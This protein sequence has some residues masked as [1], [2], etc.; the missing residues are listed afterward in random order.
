MQ[1]SLALSL[2]TLYLLATTE[3]SEVLKVPVLIHHFIEH[4]SQN[5]SLSV[6][7]FLSMHY[8]YDGKVHEG[9]DRETPLPFS[10]HENCFLSN[11]LYY[12]P[13]LP[14]LMKQ[15]VFFDLQRKNGSRS[16]F[17]FSSGYL[18]GIWQPPKQ[19]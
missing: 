1:K 2:L 16:D 10:S 4:K 3:L 5:A 6:W 8:S 19:S 11:L 15:I 12:P 18:S 17:T 9:H 7:E 13:C 14:L